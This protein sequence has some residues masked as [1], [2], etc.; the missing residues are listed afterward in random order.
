MNLQDAINNFQYLASQ[1]KGTLAEHK[2]LGESINVLQQLVNTVQS[3]ASAD[4]HSEDFQEP[5]EGEASER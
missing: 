2:A 1:F 5:W 4:D 3:S